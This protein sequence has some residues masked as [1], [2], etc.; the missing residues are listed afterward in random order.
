MEDLF[1]ILFWSG[2]IGLGI[3]LALIG[4]FVWLL[5]KADEISKRTRVFAREQGLEKKK[6]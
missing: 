6:E 3:G 2:P 5:A 1:V 4:T